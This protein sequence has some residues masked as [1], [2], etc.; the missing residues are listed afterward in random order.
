[1]ATKSNDRQETEFPSLEDILSRHGY[2][3][4][5]L[6]GRYP[7]EMRLEI[8]QLLDDWKMTGLYLDITRQKLNDIKLDNDNEEQRRVALLEAWEQREGDGATYLKLAEALHHRG[9]A[10]QVEKLCEKIRIIRDD[11]KILDESGSASPAGISSCKISSYLI[12]SQGL[13]NYVLPNS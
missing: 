4:K 12:H 6:D 13:Y 1:M 8:A 3:R 11:V 9:M 5:D 2:E 10:N 7:P